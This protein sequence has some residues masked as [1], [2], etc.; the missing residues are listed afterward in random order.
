MDK[1]ILKNIPVSPWIYKYF[2]KN[3]KIIYIWKSVNLKSRVNSYFNWT[4]KLNFAKQKMVS[5]IDKI[6]T[7]L[8]NNENEALILE[9]NLIKEHKPKYN[10]L[11]KDDKNH[12]YI[13]IFKKEW[14]HHIIKTRVKNR[15][16]EYFWPYTS[17][18]YVKNTIILIK[19]IFWYGNSD[20]IFKEIWWWYE[21]HNANAWE[22]DCLDYYIA[23]SNK[24]SQKSDFQ[25]SI[26]KIR[27]FLWWDYKDIYGQ[28]NEKM[29][30]YARNLEF[31]E[32]QKIKTYLELLSNMQEHQ[33]VK[34]FID[35]NHDIINIIN[36]YE[37]YYLWVTKIVDSKIIWYQNFKIE[38][39]LWESK[40]EII[41]F[42]IQNNYLE[43]KENLN[44]ILPFN[45]EIN[46][47][48]LEEQKISLEFP[49]IWWKLDLLRFVYKNILTFAQREHLESLSTKWFTI[50]NMET[51]LELLSYKKINK[52][53]IFE[54]NDIS[55]L[56]WTHTVASRSVI[57]NW[58]TASDKYKRFNI[59]TLTNDKIDDFESMREIMTRR[60]KEIKNTKVIPDLIIIDWWKW[61]LSSVLWILE[62]EIEKAQWE[63]KSLLE[64]LQLVSIAKREEELFLPYEKESILLDK[65]SNELR[66]IQRIRDEAHRFAI[67]FNREKR[68]KAM[69]KNILEEI[70]WIWP[71]TRQK[72]LKEFWSIEGISKA[73]KK[74]LQ[75]IMT[76]SQL[77]NLENHWII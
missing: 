36:K 16:G 59:K 73:N 9:T 27:K 72:L 57:E 70:P 48:F 50:K 12:T 22:I 74:D 52:R 2:D 32:A 66:L 5:Q 56:W 25:E 1:N 15:F 62:E 6:E 13:K 51:I 3:W 20:I 40:E 19:K 39:K 10:I 14:V 49:K 41:E 11:M 45:I 8:T 17:W 47:K 55:H 64:N 28:L 75:K 24:N 43:N 44:I 7:I 71:K 54:C 53:I 61:Q 60:I 33:V 38:N 34:D 42:F 18:S 37:G 63:D 46:N 35:W 29:L 68:N 4:S 26:D 21:L 65:D 31:E 30:N 67:T 58:K 69:K 76:K 77:E 23:R